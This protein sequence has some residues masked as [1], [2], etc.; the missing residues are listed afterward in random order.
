MCLGG[1]MVSNLEYNFGGLGSFPEGVNK[2][3]FF[4]FDIKNFLLKSN[5]VL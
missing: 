5:G 4:N 2:S 3:L 1:L